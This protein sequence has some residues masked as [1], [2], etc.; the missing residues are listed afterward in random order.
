MEEVD[1]GWN[2]EASEVI[3]F[4]HWKHLKIQIVGQEQKKN[5]P[6]EV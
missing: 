1:E 5:R 2:T 3:W 6:E 4:L